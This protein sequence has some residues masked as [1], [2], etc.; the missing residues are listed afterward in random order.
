MPRYSRARW[1]R[2]APVKTESGLSARGVSRFPSVGRESGTDT[3]HRRRRKARSIPI[4]SKRAE[5]NEQHKT[6]ET[7]SDRT[8]SLG[9]YTSIMG[10]GWGARDAKRPRRIAI[11]MVLRERRA[12]HPRT[13]GVERRI[14]QATWRGSGGES[15][16]GRISHGRWEQGG[17]DIH[18]SLYAKFSPKCIDCYENAIAGGI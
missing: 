6:A 4:A 8:I 3:P 1:R 18:V 11:I 15:V 13:L 9:S 7:R 5:K 16:R 10:R 12:L 14:E 17:Y 2:R